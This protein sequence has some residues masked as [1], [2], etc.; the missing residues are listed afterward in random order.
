MEINKNLLPENAIEETA[1]QLI[2]LSS[3]SQDDTNTISL[4][5]RDR[6]DWNSMYGSECLMKNV[7][8]DRNILVP[9]FVNVFVRNH[10]IPTEVSNICTVLQKIHAQYKEVL[11]A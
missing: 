8:Q 9:A 5:C 7:L 6:S 11:E 2:Y 4:E 10:W 3:K 1:A